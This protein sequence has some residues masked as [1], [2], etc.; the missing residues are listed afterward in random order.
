M[1]NQRAIF[2]KSPETT[3]PDQKQVCDKTI[4][5]ELLNDRKINVQTS[6]GWTIY[7]PIRQVTVSIFKGVVKIFLRGG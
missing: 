4:V 5:S 7:G 6:A 3:E 1:E 2:Q